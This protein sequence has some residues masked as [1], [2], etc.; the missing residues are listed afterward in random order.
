MNFFFRCFVFFFFCWLAACA[1]PFSRPAPVDSE[2]RDYLKQFL[3]FSNL[4]SVDAFIPPQP[5]GRELVLHFS[6]PMA[7][8]PEVGRA[9]APGF[10]TVAP[11]TAGRF[12][13]LNP[14]TLVFTAEGP[15]VA[16]TRYEVRVAGGAESLAG[17]VLV[18]GVEFEFT[19][20]ASGADPKLPITEKVDDVSH[21]SNPFPHSFQEG[22]N[23]Q[24]DSIVSPSF[25]LRDRD[26]LDLLALGI[27]VARALPPRLELPRFRIPKEDAEGDCGPLC[28]T[29]S[30]LLY[31]R[32]EENARRQFNVNLD[33][34][35]FARV[36]DQFL[37]HAAITNRSGANTRIMA[38]WESQ[39]LVARCDAVTDPVL[40]P[41]EGVTNISCFFSADETALGDAGYAWASRSDFTVSVPLVLKVS[42]DGGIGVETAFVAVR[43]ERYVLETASGLADPKA[44]AEFEK[45]ANAQPGFG[46][47][48]LRIDNRGSREVT[49]AKV[50]LNGQRIILSSLDPLRPEDGVFIPAAKLPEAMTVTVSRQRGSVLAYRFALS[51]ALS[52]P[53]H[54]VVEKG[55]SVSRA[56]FENG[57]RVAGGG[58]VKGREYDVKVSVYLE[59][60][61]RDLS[62]YDA[63]PAGVF[64]M[65][66]EGSGERVSGGVEF[67]PGPVNRGLERFSYRIRVERSGIY[68]WPRAVASDLKNSQTRGT[69]GFSTVDIR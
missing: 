41:A 64:L 60:D 10:A 53:P 15:F 38:S 69:G 39:G 54:A 21:G 37:V 62:V 12:E 67:H 42:C 2:T 36:G 1:D 6:Q 51:Y 33:S 48:D 32:L 20:S 7:P 35:A 16:G 49:S 52:V 57:K 55:M 11:A 26:V 47:L 43:N 58:L 25:G 50:Y 23:L 13:W 44:I 8:L 4:L 3:P 24:R 17:T 59:R 56:V 27:D 45:P 66:A 40:L 65:I 29:D 63:L 34:P 68:S 5:G 46:G 61:A 28:R 30:A 14:K 9:A 18:K 22:R 31:S 19:A